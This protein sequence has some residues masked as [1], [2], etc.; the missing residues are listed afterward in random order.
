M[1][2]ELQL[3]NFES[4]Y[5]F[6]G[7]TFILNNFSFL[8]MKKF[9]YKSSGKIFCYSLNKTSYLRISDSDF[10]GHIKFYNKN[11]EI[12]CIENGL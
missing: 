11:F 4:N 1:F 6:L 10:L 2:K 8:E 5:S 9:S 12:L 3:L 7:L